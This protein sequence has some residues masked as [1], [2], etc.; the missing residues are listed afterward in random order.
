MRALISAAMVAALAL[1]AFGC[2]GDDEGGNSD[3]GTQPD[4]TPQD[5][6]PGPVTNL[7]A[8]IDDTA[9]DL[10]WTNP[11]DADLANV[12][13][14]LGAAPVTFTPTDGTT[15]TEGQD[16]G[17]GE[18]VLYIGTATS[19]TQQPTFAGVEYDYA[20]FAIDAAGQFSSA[21]TTSAT[22]IA[23][24]MQTATLS[25]DLGTQ[26]VTVSEQPVNFTLSATAVY[27][28]PQNTL[29]I[30][31][32]VQNDSG[33]LIFNLKG[34][35]TGINEGSQSGPTFPLVG[36]QPYTYY[37][38]EALDVGASATRTITLTGITGGTD[39]VTV[40]LSFVDAPM[41]YGGTRSNLYAA[42]SAGSGERATVSLTGPA[43]GT[44]PRQAAISPDGRTIWFGD[45]KVAQITMVNTTTLTATASANLSS[46]GSG[47]GSIG[48]LALSGDASH[49]YVVLDEGT[50][51]HGSV[52]DMGG[53]AGT[54]DVSLVELDASDLTETGRVSLYTA[55]ASGRAGRDLVLSPDGSKA[56]VLVSSGPVTIGSTNGVINEVW[57]VNLTNLSVIDADSATAGD[58]PVTLSDTS[59]LVAHAAWRGSDL[60]TVYASYQWQAVVGSPAIDVIDT[61]TFDVTSLSVTDTH[62]SS[63]V[64]IRGDKLYLVRRQDGAIPLTVFDLATPS[65]STPTVDIT[66]SE[67]RDILFDPTGTRYYLLNRSQIAVMGVTDD[68]QIDVDGDNGNGATPIETTDGDFHDHASVISPY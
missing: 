19:T 57:L 28:D 68:T 64:A 37:G 59:Q 63:A 18:T 17:N 12:M 67:V 55:D 61:T 54:P 53:T 21:T 4:A 66:D 39:P 35:T 24:G 51:W 46:A 50:H 3:A 26:T 27:K 36:G 52:G 56:A 2:G 20:V 38:P 8:T 34:L 41:I 58:Q 14:V 1:G 13:I 11:S 60:Y 43:T 65:E 33:R 42:D 44:F 22:R 6:P 45:K 40:N 29:T 23:L 47:A 62:G 31:L 15:Y 9:I 30:D 48:G 49:L 10:A 32:T 16:L 5:L 7:T 25:V